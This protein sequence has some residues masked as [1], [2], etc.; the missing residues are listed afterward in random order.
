MITLRVIAGMRLALI[1]SRELTKSAFYFLAAL[2]L[3][4]SG[5]LISII[6]LMLAE[7]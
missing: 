3:L 6:L 2:D 5:L 1:T 7:P 4:S